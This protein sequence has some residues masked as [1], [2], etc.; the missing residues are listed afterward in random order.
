[1]IMSKE[2]IYDTP[3]P[4]KDGFHEWSARFQ[5]RQEQVH[6]P[7][8]TIEL[9]FLAIPLI[10]FIGDQHVGHPET[11]Y[12]RIEREADEIV[13]TPNSFVFMMGDYVDNLHWNPGQMDEM[14]QTPAQVEYIRSYFDYLASY[15]KL[16]LIMRGDHDGWMLKAGFDLL[17]ESAERWHAHHA[18]GITQVKARVGQQEYCIGV[19]HQLPG[20]SMYNRL[21]PQMRAERFGGLRGSDVIVSGHNHQ[22]GYAMDYQ[23]N[24]DGDREVHYIANGTYK[25]SDSWLAKKGFKR[26]Q[27]EQMF[28]SA[29]RLEAK[30]KH[31]TYFSDIIDANESHRE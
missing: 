6:K 14:E 10:N 7:H 19:A 1:M 9:T 11:D 28:G 31:V 2:F 24:F 12:A 15:N 30:K 17:T 26:Q 29:I 16:L 18:H 8:E 20:H 27:P 3:L 13:K 5:E 25:A 4:E 23:Q 22:K 21:H